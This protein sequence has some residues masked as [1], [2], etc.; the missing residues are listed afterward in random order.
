MGTTELDKRKFLE[1][2]DQ[3]LDSFEDGRYGRCYFKLI[4][5]QECQGWISEINEQ[6]FVYYDSGSLSRDEPY[7]FQV[8]DIDIDSFA[9]WDDEINRWTEYFVPN[10]F[11]NR[12]RFRN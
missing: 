6:S 2:F 12:E 5:G 3:F 11:D 9:Y 10:K 1:T 8:A 7:I 4:G